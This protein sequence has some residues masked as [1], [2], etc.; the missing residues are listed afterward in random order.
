MKLPDIHAAEKTSQGPCSWVEADNQRLRLV[1]ALE[2]GN[3][4]IE[5]LLLRG[6]A[7]KD[8][9]DEA[10]MFQL[11]CDHDPARRDRPIDRIDWR[12]L[13]NHMNRG[14]GPK[15]LQYKLIEGSHHHSFKLN[16][17]GNEGRMLHNNL[18]IAE[19]IDPD[20]QTYA[21]LVDFV[22]KCFRIRNLELPSPPW[23][24]RLL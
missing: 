5:G 7:Y 14:R 23:E 19:P 12:P 4:V 6:L 3:V 16:W 17:L 18:P 21:E 15:R 11:E 8:R 2:I 10:V 20:L 9:P 1:T 24:A 13:Q 22:K